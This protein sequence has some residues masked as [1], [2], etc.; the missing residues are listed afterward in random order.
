MPLFMSGN[1]YTAQQEA[2]AAASNEVDA[3][4]EDYFLNNEVETLIA[5]FQEK[6]GV[7]VPILDRNRL[8]GTHHE[9]VIE[10]H[11][12]WGGNQIS[13][14]GEAYDFEIP[15]EGDADMFKLR[16]NIIDSG[17]PYAEVYGNT[18][19]FTIE[20][21]VLAPE[22]VKQHIDGLLASIEKYLDWHRQTWSTHERNLLSAVRHRIDAR[23][24]RLSQQKRA[25]EKLAGLG[26]KLKE[27]EGD[28]RTYVPPTVRQK[29][30]P[31]LPPMRPATPPQPTLDKSQ[32]ETILSLVRG[33]GRSIEQSSSRTRELDEEALRDMFL[34]PLNA[35]FGTAIGE[36]FNFQGKTDVLVRHNGG[37]L[38]VA[39]FKIWAG[40]KHFLATI[41]Q[42]L[43]YLTWRDTKTAIVIFSRN[44]GFS[45]VVE[46]IRSLAKSHAAYASGP[47]RLDETSDRYIF[48]LPQDKDR[49][50]IISI[51]AFDLGPGAL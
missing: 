50:V 5:Y 37:N 2:L 27:K 43:S 49:K 32:Y 9:R 14:Q 25:A 26:I 38:F 3:L 40:D 11:D 7:V 42:L 23:R 4:P 20:G 15:F 8:V 1:S 44:A 21:P 31:V 29:I 16:P 36:A 30:Q 13:V 19:R 47:E 24:S 18:L 22:H 28:A 45:A 39:E 6:Y 51:L 48:A 35:H 10:V 17:P 46:K 12:A 41:D 34:V 33:A